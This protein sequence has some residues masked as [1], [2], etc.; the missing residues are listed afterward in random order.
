MEGI[1]IGTAILWILTAVI[2]EPLTNLCVSNCMSNRG[3]QPELVDELTDEE[4]KHWGKVATFYYVLWHVVVLGC[5][6]FVGGLFGYYFI[7]IS[8]EAK[9]W[10]G[11]LAFIG[12]SFLGLTLSSAYA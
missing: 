4:K 12:A 11:I 5:V 1:L 3:V 8:L 6:G 9:S 7:G 2:V 10:P